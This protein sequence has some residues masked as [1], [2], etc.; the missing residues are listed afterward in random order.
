MDSLFEILSAIGTASATM[1]PIHLLL[2][3]TS[4]LW[5]L[6]MFLLV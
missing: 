1:N 4:F 5:A 2:V 3:G 6:I